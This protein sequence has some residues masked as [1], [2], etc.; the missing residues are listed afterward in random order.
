MESIERRLT[1]QDYV[2]TQLPSFRNPP[3][4]ETGLLVYFDPIKELGVPRLGLL[5][6]EFRERFPVV[7]QVP[8]VDATIERTGIDDAPGTMSVQFNVGVPLPRLWFLNE[9]QD[10]LV[11][12]QSDLFGRNWRRTSDSKPYP[13]YESALR[14][15]FLDD[16][17]CFCNFLK[18]EQLPTIKP[19]QCEVVYVNQIVSGEGWQTHAD[20]DSVF[21]CQVGNYNTPANLVRENARV[22]LRHLILDHAKQFIGRLHIS[23]EPGFR[24]SDKQPIFVMTLTARGNPS[25]ADVDGVLSFLDLGRKLI[26]N[27]FTSI[28]TDTMH[29][30]WGRIS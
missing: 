17:K 19:T 11:Q 9:A 2:I 1:P 28:T 10:E 16:L 21:R 30:A 12:V 6:R 5:W 25:S 7:Q 14:E 26:V 24:R 22:Q 15:R 3:L 8:P 18:A 4:T 23:I 27:T 20:F 13:R 29:S